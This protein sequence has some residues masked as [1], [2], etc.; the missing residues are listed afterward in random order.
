MVRGEVGGVEEG[1]VE[2]GL[3]VAAGEDLTVLGVEEGQCLAVDAGVDWIVL[4]LWEEGVDWEEQ[5]EYYRSARCS[6][7]LTNWHAWGVDIWNV[8]H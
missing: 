8:S 2:E 3:E 6:D 4:G 7:Y 5:F 1:A